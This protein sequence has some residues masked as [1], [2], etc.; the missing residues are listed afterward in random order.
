MASVPH[1]FLL[2]LVALDS[3]AAQPSCWPGCTCSEEDFGRLTVVSS[4]VFLNWPAYQKHQR[5]GSGAKT[6]SSLVLA[7]HSNPWSCDCRLRGLVQLVKF[8]HFSVI[9]VDPYLMCRGPLSKAGQFVHETEL[10]ACMKP[11]VS[12]PSTNVTVQVG[13][14]VTLRCLAQASPSPTIAWT[15]PLSTWREFD[16]LTSSPTEEAAVSELLIPAAH[17]ADRGNYT[18]AAS[19]SVGRGAAVI[20]LHVQPAPALPAPRSLPVPAGGSAYVDLR[21]VRQTVHGVL[22]QW[23]TVADT[24]EETG[25]T[26]HVA[27]EA[28]PRAEQVVHVGPGIRTYALD[29]LLPGT[30]YKACLGPGVQPP[31]LGRCV[32]FVT[33]RDSGGP[34]SRERLLHVSVVLC[35][36]L[37]TVPVGAYVWAARGLCGQGGL[38]CCPHNR[39]AP[40]C[41][42]AAPPHKGDSYGDPSAV[43]EGGL[44]PR[45]TEEGEGNRGPPGPRLT[46]GGHSA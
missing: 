42:Q 33:G 28:A 18:C 2:V 25:F 34:G 36:V 35:A 24:A 3:Q 44:G 46:L 8:T 22:L 9:L 12:T 10:S 6:L 39:R 45:D 16:V 14:N 26:L 29:D 38:R 11:H 27:S 5:P 30:R 7:L 37:L 23:L 13:H 21:V 20:A 43:C 40:R 31:H 41:P 17:P 4:S 32:V 15:Y 19:N 1:Y